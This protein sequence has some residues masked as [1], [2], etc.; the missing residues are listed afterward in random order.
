MKLLKVLR[1]L[2]SKKDESAPSDAPIADAEAVESLTPETAPAESVPVEPMK[3]SIPRLALA[4]LTK[5]VGKRHAFAL[6]KADYGT[7]GVADLTREIAAARK[8]WLPLPGTLRKT[9]DGKVY[10]VDANG[11]LRRVRKVAA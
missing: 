11:S 5:Q 1:T 9:S 10:A 6:A 4:V 7:D 2:F 8:G 3:I